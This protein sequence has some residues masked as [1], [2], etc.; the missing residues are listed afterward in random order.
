MTGT[1]TP[2]ARKRIT[3][4]NLDELRRRNARLPSTARLVATFPS[5]TKTTFEYEWP[6]E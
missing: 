5:G 1:T 4:R 6:I 2:T 3:V